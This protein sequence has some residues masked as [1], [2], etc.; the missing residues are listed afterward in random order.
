[1]RHI[2]RGS[3]YPVSA[4]RCSVSLSGPNTVLSLPEA[5]R[6]ETRWQVD[7]SAPLDRHVHEGVDR[8][9][10]SVRHLEDRASRVM[11][12]S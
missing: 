5:Q 10:A 6:G 1:M 8:P 3:A 11:R 7:R 2:H 4:E 9:P 12:C